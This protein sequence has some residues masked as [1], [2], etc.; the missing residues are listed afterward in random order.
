[1]QDQ[2]VYPWCIIIFLTSIHFVCQSSI[3]TTISDA[4]HNFKLNSLHGDSFNDEGVEDGSILNTSDDENEEWESDEG[5][6]LARIVDREIRVMSELDHPHIVHLVE[7][8]E[9]K[10]VACF[11]MELAKGGE[12][13]DRLAEKVTFDEIYT[14]DHIVQLLSG[15][16]AFYI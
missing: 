9:D 4:T 6:D 5:E 7:V 8:F 3:D 14:A 13:F 16:P 15:K 1:M 11:V 10:E 2:K 12:M